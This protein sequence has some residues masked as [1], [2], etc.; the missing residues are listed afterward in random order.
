MVAAGGP[1]R[2]EAKLDVGQHPPERVIR[3]RLH[4]V[5]GSG[6]DHPTDT[7]QVIGDQ[8]VGAPAAQQVGGNRPGPV[9]ELSDDLPR[10]VDLGDQPSIRIHP[11]GGAHP[12][13]RPG[14][15]PALWVGVDNRYVGMDS[16]Q[17][18]S[19]IWLRLRRTSMMG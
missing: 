4:H 3:Q 11:A 18:G 7:A 12:V 8:R 2:L 13:H 1:E 15:Q 10:G 6:V 17:Q 14:E 19:A 16:P 5:A 9:H